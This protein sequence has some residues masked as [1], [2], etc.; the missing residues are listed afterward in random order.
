MLASFKVM[1][2]IDLIF[3]NQLLKLK[4][5]QINLWTLS[6]QPHKLLLKLIAHPEDMTTLRTFDF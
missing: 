6:T 2:E 1:C 5:F 3:I 4:V